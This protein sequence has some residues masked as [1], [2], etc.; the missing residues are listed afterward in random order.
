MKHIEGYKLK[1]SLS[2]EEIEKTIDWE[3][4][5][6]IAT[7]GE[8]H[9]IQIQDYHW[10]SKLECYILMEKIRGKTFGEV[11]L[12]IVSKLPKNEVIEISFKIF[13]QLVSALYSLHVKKLNHRD[14]KGDNILIDFS[15][16]KLL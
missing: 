13:K 16:D 4:A 8:P 1:G 6:M 15:E 14:I 11:F 7:R 5:Y 10:V 12:H 3:I 9:I 2:E